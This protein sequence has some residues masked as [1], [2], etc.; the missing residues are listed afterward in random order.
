MNQSGLSLEDS[1]TLDKLGQYLKASE[2]L[3]KSSLSKQ[4]C[5]EATK[6]L[7]QVLKSGL[8][9]A[10]NGLESAVED[11]EA[12]IKLTENYLD[13]DIV[14][15]YL[16]ASEALIYS[17]EW[18]ERN[19]LGLEYC[20]NYSEELLETHLYLYRTL[21]DDLGIDEMKQSVYKVK[22]LME[23]E[24]MK[25]LK[26]IIDNQD[27]IQSKLTL[28]QIMRWYERINEWGTRIDEVWQQLAELMNS[29]SG[30]Q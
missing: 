6:C 25:I 13:S 14:K 16:V 28:D 1:I 9:Q 17:K 21:K 11:A 12:Y 4:Y 24:D 20:L 5:E 15:Q 3:A 23:S 10:I 19:K 7:D 29:L 27:T 18:E 22:V 26:Q 2:S 30:L 8:K